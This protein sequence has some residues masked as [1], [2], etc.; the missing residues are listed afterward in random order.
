MNNNLQFVLWYPFGFITALIMK[1]LS[2]LFKNLRKDKASPWVIGGHKGGIYADNS[3]ALH[4]YIISQ[5]SQPIIWIA[6][7]R[8]YGEMKRKGIKVL[9][10]DS[11]RARL[12]ILRAPILIYSHGLDDL[13]TFLKK[14]EIKTGNLIYLNHSMNFLKCPAPKASADFLLAVSEEEKNNFSKTF[15][16][17]KRILPVGGGAHLDKILK[18]RE[19][20]PENLIL[21]F[22]TWRDTKKEAEYAIEFQNKVINSAKLHAYLEKNGL[23]LALVTHINTSGVLNSSH[24]SVSLHKQGDLSGLFE[25]ACVFISDYSGIIFDW[26]ALDRPV[27]FFPFDSDSYKKKRNF[28]YPL[29]DI[30]Y[31]PVA[32]TE[33]EF[34]EILTGDTWKNTDIFAKKRQSWKDKIFS[35]GLAPVYSEKCYETIKNFSTALNCKSF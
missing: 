32:R 20:A 14:I 10:K 12:A 30:Y 24:S 5:T 8:L 4:G 11:I 33:E 1:L 22:P 21:W 19:K 2:P 6:G 16:G 35:L 28:Y 3:A 15:A 27:I 31:G 9:K 13:D 17:I 18:I 34:F 7:T 29:E 23:R 26:L 25:K